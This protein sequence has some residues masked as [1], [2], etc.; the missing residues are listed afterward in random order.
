MSLGLKKCHFH[1]GEAVVIVLKDM[2]YIPVT[3]WSHCKTVKSQLGIYRQADFDLVVKQIQMRKKRS[4]NINKYEN[5][6][7][8][9]SSLLQ[10]LMTLCDVV[11]NF[12][13]H[14]LSHFLEG[15]IQHFGR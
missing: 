8:I 15:T 7:I 4:F 14:F 9:K 6:D 12:F 2:L 11:K 1:A 5:T 3:L 10:T 13:Q